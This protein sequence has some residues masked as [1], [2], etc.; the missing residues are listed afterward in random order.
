[1]ACRVWGNPWRAPRRA[2]RV[3][4]VRRL[5][6]GALL[7]RAIPVARRSDPW[8]RDPRMARGD[9]HPR[10]PVAPR[11]TVARV[12]HAACVR[13][14]RPSNHGVQLTPLA[15]FR[16]LGAMWVPSGAA[17]ACLL[18]RKTRRP[19]HSYDTRYLQERASSAIILLVRIQAS[20]PRM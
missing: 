3:G 2:W 13:R 15:R 1:M 6:A 17:N 12:S 20:Q 9:G 19:A 16:G 7:A 14:P 10:P 8:R 18:G 5:G 4:C 11:P